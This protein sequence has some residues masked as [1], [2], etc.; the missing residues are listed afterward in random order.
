[1]KRFQLLVTLITL[2]LISS[3]IG[4]SF[5][6]SQITLNT[7]K[8]SYGPGDTVSITGNINSA[9]AGELVGIQVKDPE[10]NLIVIRTVQTDSSGNFAIQFKVPTTATSG[11]FI[12]EASAKINGQSVDGTKTIM[13][14]VPEFPFAALTLI[15]AT[16]SIILISRMKHPRD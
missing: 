1:M 14:T 9:T 15:I 16:L 12:I 13:Q 5:E 7:D 6:E 10:G 8:S 4:F 3:G 11:N 2:G